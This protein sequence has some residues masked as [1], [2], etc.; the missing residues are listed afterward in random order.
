MYRL[1]LT[2]NLRTLF[3]LLIASAGMACCG[4]LWWANQTG[5][6]ESWRALIER[7]AEKQGAFLEIGSLRY[8]PLR[9]LIANNV[10]V[11]SDPEHLWKLSQLEQ[12]VLVFDKSKLARGIFQLTKVELKDAG[13]TLPVNP[14]DPNSDALEVTEANGTL[15]MPGNRRLEVREAHGKIAGINIELDAQL[16]GYQES[17][18]KPTDEANE[19]KRRAL[20]AKIIRELNEWSFDENQPPSL[21]VSLEG[22]AN[23]RTTTKATVTLKATNIGKNQHH[24]DAVTA[25]ADMSGDLL[26]ITSLRASDPSGSFQGHIDYNLESREGRFEINSS[27]EVPALLK[28]WL[29]IPALKDITISGKQTLKAEGDFLIDQNHIPE[30]RM[31]G[32]ARCESVTLRGMHFNAVETAFSWR[33]QT[34]FLRDV[35]LSR[36]DG[37]ALGKAMIQWPQ[38]RIAINSTL[39]SNVYKPFFVGMPLEIVLNDFTTRHGAAVNVNLEGGFDATDRFSWAYTGSGNLQNMNYKGVPVNH[40][41]CKFSLNH[42]ELDFFDGNVI[43]NYDTYPL[44]TAFN[45][46]NQ[47]TAKVGRIRYDGP[48]KVVEVENVRGNIWAAPMVRFFA[49]QVADSLEQYRFHHPPELEASGVVDVTPQGRTALKVAFKSNKPADYSFLGENV[50]LAQPRGNV[51]IRGERVTI[52]N[53]NFEVFNGPVSS[54][55]DYRG[56][57]LL[58]GELNWTNLSIPTLA[59]T[60][61]FQMK[62]GGKAT[63]RIRFDLTNN[64]MET[65]NGEGL[66][67]MENAELFSVPMFGPL[68]RLISSVLNDRAAGSERANDAFCNFTIKQGILNTHDFQTSTASLN[69][70]GDGD[71]NLMDRTLNMTM[72]MNARGLLGL[73]TLPLRPFYGLFQFRGTGPLK[74]TTWQNEIFTTPP[75]EQKPLFKTPPKATIINE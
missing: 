7:E 43:F 18:P 5:L 75:P 51:A 59:S 30:I 47:G 74:D 14:K 72:R 66:L 50:T 24:L 3:F 65:M 53:L 22:N 48:S 27:L 64:Q 16:I 69:F 58:E 29:G 8:I 38:V 49:P 67:A 56:K 32:H 35:R 10:H 34:A 70:T 9:G 6:P 13:L 19:G 55:F 41:D 28:A 25:T 71:I 39:P 54:H 63:G 40:A 31:T 46:P 57:G 73:I 45:G 52:S 12:V 37:E 62:Q 23:D 33:D 44:K 26:T 1:N 11:F 60:Y 4:L 2:R 15:L 42:H 21:R 68:T 20:L 17:K 36:N 61:G